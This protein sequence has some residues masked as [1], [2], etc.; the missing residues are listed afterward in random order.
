MCGE[1]L[2]IGISHV[3]SRGSSPHVRGAQTPLRNPNTLQG[4]IPAC[5]GSTVRKR[6]ISLSPW[7]HPR[8]CGEHIT[9]ILQHAVRTGSSPHVRGALEVFVGARNGSGIIPACAGSTSH[10]LLSFRCGWDHP[11]MCGEHAEAVTGS[12]RPPGSSP[13]VRGAPRER[14]H[15]RQDHGIIPACAGS[16]PSP[17]PGMTRYRGSSPHVRGALFGGRIVDAEVGIIPACAGST[18]QVARIVIGTRDHPRMCGEHITAT[19]DDHII[20]GSSP[21]VR[22]APFHCSLIHGW[23]GIIPAC[24]GSTQS[25][26][27]H[28]LSARDHPRM[29]GEHHR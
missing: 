23:T 1:H 14:L 13:H 9:R 10:M 4:I 17:L 12:M 21:H 28:H 8:M 24:A 19:E 27:S 26:S 2:R 11:R 18:L 29:C 25:F 16:T 15:Q 5:A 7:D 22:G 20:P 3:F 6:K